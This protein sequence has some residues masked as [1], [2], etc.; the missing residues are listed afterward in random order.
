MRIE[1][2]NS[3]DYRNKLC[4]SIVTQLYPRHRSGKRI[5]IV[6]DGSRKSQKHCVVK[7]W[8]YN[9]GDWSTRYAHPRLSEVIV[10]SPE[11]GYFVSRD[12]SI[13]YVP[14]GRRNL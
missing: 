10:E 2:M 1:D 13:L 8:N 3:R 6:T 5:G 11:L 9:T 4:G 7:W 12:G 14:E